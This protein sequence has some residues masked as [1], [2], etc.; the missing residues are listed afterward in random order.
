MRAASTVE[1]AGNLEVLLTE[2]LAKL[3]ALVA[4]VIEAELE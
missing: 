2:M 3:D 1:M 4:A